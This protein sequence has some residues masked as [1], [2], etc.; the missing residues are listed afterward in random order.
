MNISLRGVKLKKKKKKDTGTI[1]NNGGDDGYIE[2]KEMSDR[3]DKVF[4][5]VYIKF[6]LYIYTTNFHTPYIY[7]H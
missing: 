3:L 4:I 5:Y 6:P 1:E 2:R 7:L